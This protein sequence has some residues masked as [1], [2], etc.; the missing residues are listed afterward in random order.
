MCPRHLE[1]V[2]VLI[3]VTVLW[4][5]WLIA[6]SI[7]VI[8]ATLPLT[9]VPS[10]LLRCFSA[11]ISFPKRFAFMYPLGLQNRLWLQV[12]ACLGERPLAKIHFSPTLH[13]QVLPHHAM[14]SILAS[15]PVRFD[16]SQL[17]EHL[18]DERLIV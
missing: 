2:W 16:S 9:N 13:T 1:Y 6:A 11:V 12:C 10:K 3:N 18:A 17:E 15:S 4:C 8:V 14:E 7:V 5:V